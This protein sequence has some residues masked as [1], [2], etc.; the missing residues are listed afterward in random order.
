[1]SAAAV[2]LKDIAASRPADV[3]S[4]AEVLARYRQL[5]EISKQHHSAV[6]KFLSSDAI[7]SQARRLGLAQGKTLVAD[8][9]N[10]LNLAF[11]LAI[12]TA[13]KDRSRAIDRYARAARLAPE[14]DESL[15]LEAMRRA[16]FSIISFVRRHPVA[17]LIVKD[18]FRD[19]EVWL[20]D[21]G[22]ET[23]LSDGGCR[24]D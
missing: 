7:M 9:M 4:R 6:L 18:V 12:H 23:S 11:D 10:D 14:S 8:S 13:S 24:L 16:R 17:G 19:D 20:V 2:L 1:M 3:L 22:L 5:R 15:V 21:E